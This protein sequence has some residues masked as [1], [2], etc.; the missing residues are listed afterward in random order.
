[1]ISANHTC[2]FRELRSFRLILDIS[3]YALRQRGAT[4]LKP[5]CPIPKSREWID[6]SFLGP[7]T[8]KCSGATQGLYKSQLSLVVSGCHDLRWSA[9]CFVNAYEAE[10]ESFEDDSEDK[11]LID[12]LHGGT[13]PLLNAISDAREYYLAVAEERLPQI[14]D[15]WSDTVTHVERCIRDHVSQV[16]VWV[17]RRLIA[18]TGEATSK[19]NS[20]WDKS[21][22]N[23]RF[24]T[25]RNGK[26][27]PTS[28]FACKRA[29]HYHARYQQGF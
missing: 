14:M 1:M 16:V 9:Y 7:D 23:A 4:R 24:N 25:K 2:K 20:N 10:T 12:R 19:N 22:I 29:V 18:D 21:L 3:Y 26:M 15:E 8:S 13:R 5:S 17:D 27:D 28:S 6:L 11:V